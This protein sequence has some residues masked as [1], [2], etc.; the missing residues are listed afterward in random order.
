MFGEAA[1]ANPVANPVDKY[2]ETSDYNFRIL[3]CSEE[4]GGENGDCEDQAAEQGEEHGW[5]Y[6]R[7]R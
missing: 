7:R 4:D 5:R 6:G 1:G 3:H 2:V